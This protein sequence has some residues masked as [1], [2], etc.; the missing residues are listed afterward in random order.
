MA[1]SDLRKQVGVLGF[2]RGPDGF[3]D[4]E[5]EGVQLALLFLDTE[6]DSGGGLE[7]ER[8]HRPHELLAD[9]AARD[10]VFQSLRFRGEQDVIG[11]DD[12]TA[13]RSLRHRLPCGWLHP[14]AF[15]GPDIR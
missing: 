3:A 10:A 12:E 2:P 4:L 11:P 7:V 13:R 6:F 15:Q 14:E 8:H 5:I 9:Q 1:T